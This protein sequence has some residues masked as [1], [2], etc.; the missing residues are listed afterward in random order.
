MLTLPRQDILTV[1]EE[2]YLR[3]ADVELAKKVVKRAQQ[4][5]DDKSGSLMRLEGLLLRK[6]T[7]IS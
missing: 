3:Q 5:L 7:N 1:Q 2:V 6:G 4:L